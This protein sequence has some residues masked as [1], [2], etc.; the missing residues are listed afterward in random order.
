MQAP[1]LV[2]I[3]RSTYAAYKGRQQICKVVSIDGSALE[4]IHV[5][6]FRRDPEKFYEDTPA[7]E[8]PCVA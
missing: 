3:Q 7:Q 2:L 6:Q 4:A 1:Q 8:S 5:E